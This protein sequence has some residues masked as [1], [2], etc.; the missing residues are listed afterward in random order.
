[1]TYLTALKSTTKDTTATT[2]CPSPIERLDLLDLLD[3]KFLPKDRV[4]NKRG[5]ISVL[6][7]MD[8]EV[9]MQTINDAKK[10]DAEARQQKSIDLVDLLDK[11]TRLPLEG[12]N[13][14]KATK[15]HG[16]SILD[17]MSA[18]D[19]APVVPINKS[20]DLIGLLDEKTRLPR[21]VKGPA[22]EC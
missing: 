15:T 7:V 2:T 22:A 21:V 14:G 5:S 9:V 10:R 13:H 6:D 4:H 12:G 3:E 18:P 11:H 17:V 1:M 16:V 20:V 8:Q 19:C